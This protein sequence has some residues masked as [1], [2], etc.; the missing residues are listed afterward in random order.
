MKVPP[1]ALK[2]AGLVCIVGGVIGWPV[3]AFTFGK[4]EPPVTLG[5]SWFAIIGTGFAFYT[6]AQDGEVLDKIL[7]ILKKDK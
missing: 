2:F 5:L 6:A 1:K 3:S 4:T 7:S